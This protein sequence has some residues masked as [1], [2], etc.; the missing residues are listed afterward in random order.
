MPRENRSAQRRRA[1]RLLAVQALYQMELN[2]TPLPLVIVEFRAHRLDAGIDAAH[3]ERLLRDADGRRDDIDRMLGAALAKGWTVERLEAVLRALMRAG[4][5]EL[6]C[7]A[8]VP[9]KVVVAQ[10]VD[11]ARG[12]FTGREPA[13]VNGVLDRLARELRPDEFAPAGSPTAAMDETP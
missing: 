13:M 3:F 12:F 4:A 1:A 7:R 10:F 8:D 11:I 9:A 2:P 5:A 6:L